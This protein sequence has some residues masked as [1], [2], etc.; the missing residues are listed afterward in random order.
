MWLINILC[1]QAN[2]VFLSFT[3]VFVFSNSSNPSTINALNKTRADNEG[4]LLHNNDTK[5]YFH[6]LF[7]I[8]YLANCDIK[9][10]SDH[11]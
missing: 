4:M 7:I 1:I 8:V 3:Q 10:L 2:T 6:V 11:C 5:A 9:Q